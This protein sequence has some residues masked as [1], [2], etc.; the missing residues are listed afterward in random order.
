MRVF[1]SLRGHASAPEHAYIPC[2]RSCQGGLRAGETEEGG[3]KLS[4]ELSPKL[5]CQPRRSESVAA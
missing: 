3:M 2:M 1:S 5:P 4:R